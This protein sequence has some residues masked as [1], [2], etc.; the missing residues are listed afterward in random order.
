MKI[1]KFIFL[2]NP[3]LVMRVVRKRKTAKKYLQEN[4]QISD[5]NEIGQLVQGLCWATVTQRIKKNI[6]VS[7]IFSGK[8]RQCL[9]V[10]FRMYFKL[11]NFVHNRCSHCY[12]NF[13]L[14]FLMRTTLNFRVRAKTKKRVRY[15]C[16]RTLDVDFE[17]D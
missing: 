4:S 10:G 8:N 3:K 13:N 16:E 2:E 11:T 7:G 5:F 9:V 6:L 14:F 1:F 15:I 17:R 12:E